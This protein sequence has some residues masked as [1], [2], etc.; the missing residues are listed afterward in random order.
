[1]SKCQPTAGARLR[2]LRLHLLAA[3]PRSRECRA[4][5]PFDAGDPIGL[6]VISTRDRDHF[7][8]FV[9]PM[10]ALRHH[11]VTSTA[12]SGGKRAFRVYRLG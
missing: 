3:D 5:Q 6:F 9:F 10:A 1:M 4:I 12:G 2:A 8:Q 7:G 11:G